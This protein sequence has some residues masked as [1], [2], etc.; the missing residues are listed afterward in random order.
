M[1]RVATA[2]VLAPVVLAL[3][4]VAPPWAWAT[5]L[6]LAA[7]QVAREILAMTHPLDPFA[8]GVGALLAAGV[9]AASYGAAHDPRLFFSAT[10]FALTA[11]AVLPLVRLGDVRTAALRM[12]ATM[13]APLY[14]GV[15]LS[16]L[17][18]L[19][20]GA[21]DE[22]PRYV[23]FTLL[24]AWMADTGGYT[25]GR[26][27]GKTK[28][29]EAVSPK[30]TREGLY[31]SMLFAVV[32]SAIASL[33]Y[34]P[35]LPITHAALL[36]FLGAILGQTGDLVESLLKRSTGVKDSGNIL[37]GHG[38]L[39]DRVD[40]LLFVGPLVYCYWLWLH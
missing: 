16:C 27:F 32:V 29:Y 39:F 22:G 30:K 8:R 23:L 4:F 9:C 36:G 35:T 33:T 21:E 1:V 40:A 26:L 37:P 14:V 34:L 2:L 20:A 18:L 6:C 19:R 11:G 28:L 10:L 12:L 24:I 7:A 5:F 15:T 3:L 31:G 17:A 13:S 25:L 38:G